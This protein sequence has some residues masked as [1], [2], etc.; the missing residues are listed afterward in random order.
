MTANMLPISAIFNE[1][2]ESERK[3]VDST[4]ECCVERCANDT[5]AH[6]TMDSINVFGTDNNLLSTCLFYTEFLSSAY[7]E[8]TS[9]Y[10]CLR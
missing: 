2:I 8:N 9:Y 4:S 6:F 7:R 3:L 10:R 5:R 1:T